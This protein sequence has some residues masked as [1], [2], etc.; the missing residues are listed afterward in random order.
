MKTNK[1]FLLIVS[2]LLLTFVSCD[3]K[4]FPT[5][6]GTETKDNNDTVAVVTID[7][8]KAISLEDAK[9][10]IGEEVVVKGYVTKSFAVSTKYEKQTQSAWLAAS[11]T[12][13]QGVIE[14]YYAEI[15]D[16]VSKGDYVAVEG[17][18]DIYVKSGST[19]T[20]FEIVNG[21]MQILVKAGSVPVA[22]L[23]GDGTIDNPFTTA[24]VRI[25]DNSKTGTYYVKGYIVGCIKNGSKT[26]DGNVLTSGFDSN[27]NIVIAASADE[28]DEANMVPVQLPS[29]AVRTA[30]NV[31]DNET[32]VGQEVLLYGSLEAYFSR[33]G[34][35]NISYAQVGENE[36]GIKPTVITGD[37]LLNETLLT[38]ASYDKFTAI[39]VSGDQVWSFN[40]KYGA[41]MSGFADN[42]SHENE[43]WFISPAFDATGALPVLT[44]EHARGPKGSMIVSTDNYTVW[45]SNDYYDTDAAGAPAD[46]NSVTW[47][48][49]EYL[50]T[51][52]QLG[53]L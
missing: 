24:D 36:Y 21:K 9:N 15:T 39:S 2:A 13:T 4:R 32:N 35:K 50:L 1:L 10:R 46:P 16:S 52:L 51:V 22:D 7:T 44:F 20:T 34:V 28:T 41:V 33:A 30:L 18:V 48:Q 27:T 37:V 26:M 3:E 38:Q 25:L 49:I 17:K 8:T 11:S 43:D 5:R 19:D 53:A 14:A 47:T 40:S 6:P 29:G 23:E 42:A 31:V 12:A 45:V